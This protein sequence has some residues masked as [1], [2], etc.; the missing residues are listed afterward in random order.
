[1]S[2]IRWTDTHE[3]PAAPSGTP[4]PALLGR[5]GAP[6]ALAIVATLAAV[7]MALPGIAS[8]Y[9]STYCGYGSW[10]H[11]MTSDTFA[12]HYDAGG[13]HWHKVEVRTKTGQRGGWRLDH[14]DHV[15]CG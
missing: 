1:M 3:I 12:G 11:G 2:G 8:A 15:V 13:Q 14:I 6:L 4:S 9:T 10:R 5:R 7:V